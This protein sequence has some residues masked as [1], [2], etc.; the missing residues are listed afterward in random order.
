M[1][2]LNQRI[3]LDDVWVE[4]AGNYLLQKEGFCQVCENT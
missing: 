3:F 2:F 1:K 4:G